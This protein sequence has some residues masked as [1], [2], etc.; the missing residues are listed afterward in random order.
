[1]DNKND[2]ILKELKLKKIKNKLLL[3]FDI[4][5]SLTKICILTEKKEKEINDLLLSKKKFE[6]IDLNLY[7]LYLTCFSTNNFEKNLSSLLS[8]LNKLIKIEEI[9][10]TGGG[11]YKFF[12]LVKNNFN[13]EFQKHDE[14][15]SLKFG[16]EFMNNYNSFYEI[17]MDNNTKKKVNVD[18]LIFPHISTNIGSGVSIL[19]VS[20]PNKY[21]RI[22]GT[23]MG[24][25]TLVGL[26]KLIFGIDDFDEILN[27]ASKGNHENVD[28]MKKDILKESKD[29]SDNFIVSS[30]GK[31]HEFIQSGKKEEIKKEDIS[32]SLLKM[33]CSHIAQY[34]VIYAEQC[35]IDTIYYFGTFTKKDSIV[36]DLLNEASKF[37]NK[38][39]KVRFN[40]YSG[41]LGAIGTLLE[42]NK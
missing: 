34:S 7:N 38:D 24:G 10:A 30:L 9:D 8:E 4:G 23:L 5:G 42:Q 36:D 25:G 2:N 41:Y 22:G 15:Q 3:G 33:I 16:Y 11:A 1:M 20:T 19:K 12:N 14:L 21:E 27:L 32:L 17:R 40:Y 31:I 35:K 37:W 29:V 28:L 13:I 6:Y 18:N 26:S 39:I